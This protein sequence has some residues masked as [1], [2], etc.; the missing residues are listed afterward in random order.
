MNDVTLKKIRDKIAPTAAKIS[1]MMSFQ[2]KKHSEFESY[3][4]YFIT[5]IAVKYLC[6]D[7]E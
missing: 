7:T 1:P 3:F 2:V 6:L 4:G 5:T